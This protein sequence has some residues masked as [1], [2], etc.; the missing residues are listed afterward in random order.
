MLVKSPLP[1]N[2]KVV[3]MLQIALAGSIYMAGM[4]LGAAVFCRLSDFIGRKLTLILA[5]L[6]AAAAQLFSGF[7]N[8]YT[9]FALMRLLCGMSTGLY[10]PA[11][12]ISLEIVGSSYRNFACTVSS[13]PFALGEALTGV[14]AYFVRDWRMFYYTSS[15]LFVLTAV[16]YFF[17]PES[18]RYSDT[19]I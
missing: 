5:T 17:I 18:P 6:I 8:D 4:F 1:V 7:T 10:Y 3:M 11:Y 9:T 16:T 2:K 13:I 14:W 15:S 19:P 12:T